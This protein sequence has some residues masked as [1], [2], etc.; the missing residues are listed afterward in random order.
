[1]KKD[2]YEREVV[3]S[4]EKFDKDG[5]GYIDLQELGQLQ[6]DLGQPL[7]PEK[8]EAAMKEL[9]LN[10]DGVIDKEEFS[11]WYFTGMKS[12][13]GLTRTML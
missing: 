6:A 2:I 4:F 7:E 10:G 1:M 5:N 11:R 8:L 3:A 12:Y 13:S 9:D